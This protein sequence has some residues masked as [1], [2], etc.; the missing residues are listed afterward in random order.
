MFGP[1]IEILKI[2]GFSVRI[3]LSWLV[4]VLLIVWTLASGA[5]PQSHPGLGAVTYWAMA[6]VAAAGLFASIL[7]HEF[8]HSLVARRV[9]MPIGGITLFIFGGVAE[10]EKE[11]PT[12]RAE[13]QM[14]I[15]GPIASLILAGLFF[16]VALAGKAAA[17]PVPVTGV[18]S[19]LALINFVLALFNLVPAFPLDGGRVFRAILWGRR[20][21]MASATRT[22][23]RIGASF[24][25]LLM[26]L[27]G[28]TL[29]VF[30]NL[31]GGVWWFLIGMFLR[32]AAHAEVF[33]LESSQFLGG[34]PVSNF[35][36]DTL[37]TVPPGVTVTGFVN[38]YVYRY[39]HSAYPVAEGD[40]VLGL[41]GMRQVRDTP[42]DRW[43]L[44]EVQAAMDPAT[45]ETCIEA[46][47]PAADALRAMQKSGEGRLLV[48][49]QGRL[50]GMITLKDLMGAIDLAAQVTR[51]RQAG[52]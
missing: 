21:D 46:D 20:G 33:R 15:A 19:Y 16:L 17:L 48:T 29:F 13:L 45:A 6:V 5:F 3:D 28:V 27:G 24:G 32:G 40:R 37:I 26:V 14:A 18:A 7:I 8:S 4:L 23:A 41:I 39:H 49:R 22:A 35:M 42:A 31:V 38:D 1:R 51:L 36:T 25:I 11:P 10:M 44:V 9:G 12:A 50:V 2:L 34:Q 30:G 43:D 47:Q 52:D